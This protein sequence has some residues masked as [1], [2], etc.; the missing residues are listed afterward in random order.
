MGL[1]TPRRHRDTDNTPYLS[2]IKERNKEY[3]ELTCASLVTP[4][5]SKAK[6][7]WDNWDK[8]MPMACEKA[9]D[10]LNEMLNDPFQAVETWLKIAAANGKKTELQEDLRKKFESL[11]KKKY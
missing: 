4:S 11:K 10:K 7:H 8:D 1:R 2:Q 9:L 5:E 3:N 6:E